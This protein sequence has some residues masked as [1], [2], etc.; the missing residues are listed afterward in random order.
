[1][2][3][4]EKNNVVTEG[5]KL[6]EAGCGWGLAGI[7]AAR[8][9]AEVTAVDADRSVFPYVELHERVNQVQV[10]MIR[11]RFDALRIKDLQGQQIICGGDVCFWDELVD[12]WYKLIGR[13]FRAGV[14]RVVLA[15]PGRISFHELAER[16]LERWGTDSVEWEINDPRRI[17]GY[18]LDI[19]KTD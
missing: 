16:C 7:Y 2:D 11:R 5:C 3:Y 12:T 1:M 4:F 19:K 17:T 14:N 6:L 13:A 9:G 8:N 18:V 15:D 10:N